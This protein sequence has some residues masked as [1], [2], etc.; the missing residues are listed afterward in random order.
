MNTVNTG[1]HTNPYEVQVADCGTKLWVHAPDG[2]TVA[3]FSK[4]FGIDLH[5]TATEQMKGASECL[6]CTH[7]APSKADWDEFRARLL[8][9]YGVD[10]APNLMVFSDEN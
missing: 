7:S 9:A 8:S 4:V 2:S 10:L 1:L 5:T 3:R 6:F